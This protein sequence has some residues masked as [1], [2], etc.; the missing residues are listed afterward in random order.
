MKPAPPVTSAFTTGIE[1]LGAPAS[2]RKPG[3]ELV[4]RLRAD[5]KHV[6]VPLRQT[7][8]QPALAGVERR[9]PALAEQLELAHEVLAVL[10]APTQQS[11]HDDQATL[12]G[13]PSRELPRTL[14]HWALPTLDVDLEQRRRGVRVE[15]V[16]PGDLHELAGRRTGKPG[17]QR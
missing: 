3:R 2:D 12:A 6:R 8:P 7:A 16:E 14:E 10:V 1:P 9:H 13:E 4:E 17:G 15:V 11:L 5:E